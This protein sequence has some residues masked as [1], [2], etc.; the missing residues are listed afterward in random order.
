MKIEQL[1]YIVELSNTN[2]ITKV[3]EK[4][5]TSQSNISLQLKQLEKEIGVSLLKKTSKGTFFTEDGK[6]F[7]EKAKEIVKGFDELQNFKTQ[8][9]ISINIS[10]MPVALISKTAIHFE[11]EYEEANM[12]INLLHRLKVEEILK[13]IKS[14][15]SEIG[16]ISFLKSKKEHMEQIFS[17]YGIKF[18]QL[19]E[20][21]IYAYFG[22]INTEID[23]NSRLYVKDLEKFN[24]LHLGTKNDKF[25]DCLLPE[26]INAF[27]KTIFFNDLYNL[28]E[29]ERNSN[30]YSL[31]IARQFKGEYPL[32][33]ITR[34]EIYDIE[35]KFLCGYLVLNNEKNKY[36]DIFIEFLTEMIG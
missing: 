6:K 8:K 12:K 24:H 33:G 5:F 29:F 36:T 27:G 3:A 1:R 13:D 21:A 2:S 32:Q 23:L 25:N 11:Q 17:L 15:T 31:G 4:M 9:K 30:S 7:L 18:I 35:D 26:K 22:Q 34:K 19:Y 16:C 14:K 10:T 28:F 20:E